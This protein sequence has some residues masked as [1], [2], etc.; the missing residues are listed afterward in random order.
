MEKCINKFFMKNEKILKQDQFKGDF[1]TEGKSIYEVIRVINGVPIFLERHLERLEKSADLTKLIVP[2]SIKEI[3]EKLLKLIDIN[4]KS[5]GNIKLLLNYRD[6]Y[7][8]I[9]YAYFIEHHYPS[10]EDY[11]N[12]VDTI[13]YQAERN[14]PAAKVANVNFREMLNKKMQ[15][16]G[17][18][19]L[20]LK[21]RAGFITEGSRANIFMVK[22]NKLITAPSSMVLE[23]ITRGV[24][25][26]LAQK[27]DYTIEEKGI[28]DSE[29]INMDAFFITGTSPKVLPI[30]RVDDMIFNSSKNQ[31]V[32]NL[33]NEY[34]KKIKEYIDKEK[35][36]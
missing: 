29:I 34:N 27:L 3:K 8:C 20:I 28:K 7:S 30:K 5:K 4:Q 23:G 13:S 12:G 9:F 26:S 33:M 19:E 31:L 11:E 22:D 35:T 1:I 24:V 6:K 16:T 10:E 32:K 25:I 15:E 17:V 18:F 2:L 21:D 14:N 36:S